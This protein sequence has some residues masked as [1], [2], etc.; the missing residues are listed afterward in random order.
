MLHIKN[1]SKYIYE[2]DVLG[3][4]KTNKKTHRTRYLVGKLGFHKTK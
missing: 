2:S 4:E 3:V 1:I